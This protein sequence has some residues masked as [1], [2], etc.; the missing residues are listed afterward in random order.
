MMSY[1]LQ[2]K[3]SDMAMVIVELFQNKK[4]ARTPPHMMMVN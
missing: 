4:N 2:T 3:R 1:V